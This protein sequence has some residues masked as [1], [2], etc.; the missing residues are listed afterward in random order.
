MTNFR[1][2]LVPNARN[3]DKVWK[4]AYPHAAGTKE[5]DQLTFSKAGHPYSN[6]LTMRAGAQADKGQYGYVRLAVAGQQRF[7][8]G[9]PAFTP[10]SLLQA[11]WD[12]SISAKGEAV[13]VKVAVGWRIEGTGERDHQYEVIFEREVDAGRKARSAGEF[14][15]PEHPYSYVG[16]LINVIWDVRVILR[17]R[18]QTVGGIVK[19]IFQRFEEITLQPFILCPAALLAQAE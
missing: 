10:G 15:L 8:E 14:V 4:Q 12:V 16:K 5:Y 1:W 7:I 13:L 19:G 9:L 17:N 18:P 6:A 11:E 2:P 3:M